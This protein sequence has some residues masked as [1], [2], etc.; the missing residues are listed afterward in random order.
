[1]PQ[2]W[3]NALISPVHKKGF[4]HDPGNY[5]PVSLTSIICKLQE[6]HSQQHA[7]PLG[8]SWDTEPRP[9]WVRKRLSTETQLIQAVHDWASTTDAKGETDVLF[10]DFSKAFDTVP[11]R[12]LL[13]KLQHYGI[14][15][16]TSKWIASLLLGRRQRVIVNGTGSAWSPV[17]SGVPQGTVI[18]TILFFIYIN[19]ITCDITNA[20]LC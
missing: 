8:R 7:H 10:L 17:L 3:R 1:M 19:D 6:H 20:T 18:G 12:R 14:D 5:R 15:G 13:M 11:H 4:K 2:G 9:A 16:K